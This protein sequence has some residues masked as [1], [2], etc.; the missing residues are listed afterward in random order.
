M[1]G[2]CVFILLPRLGSYS[3]LELAIVL[4]MSPRVSQVVLE[5]PS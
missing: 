1:L 3:L 5:I 4:D 2:V